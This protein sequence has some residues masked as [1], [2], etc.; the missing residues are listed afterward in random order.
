MAHFD[1]DD[2]YIW[3]KLLSDFFYSVC[4]FMLPI[5]CGSKLKSQIATESN[6][7]IRK[8]RQTTLE[9]KIKK[10]LSIIL[11]LSER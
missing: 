11:L 6:L 10:I 3:D 5:K 4:L 8:L 7:I 9:Q 2:L 1:A